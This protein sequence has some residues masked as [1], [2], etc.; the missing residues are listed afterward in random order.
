MPFQRI[1]YIKSR[2]NNNTR[3]KLMNSLLFNKRR[4]RDSK[5]FRERERG[6][7]SFLF[8]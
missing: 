7:V 1:G 2:E 3:G 4:K 6:N 5:F 8:N